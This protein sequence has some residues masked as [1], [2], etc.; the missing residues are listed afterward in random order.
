MYNIILNSEYESMVILKQSEIVMMR[1]MAKAI[2]MIRPLAEYKKV[3]REINA[4]CRRIL[5]VRNPDELHRME[6]ASYPI[7]Q[8]DAIIF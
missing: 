1:P 2:V 4:S 3:L 7:L 8:F 6:R 5:F